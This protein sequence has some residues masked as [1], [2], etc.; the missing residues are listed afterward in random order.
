ML[1]VTLLD[2]IAVGVPVARLA[3]LA[4]LSERER[5]RVRVAPSGA[6][7][8]WDEPDA[9]VSV[10]ELLQHALANPEW[11]RE[12]ARM[13]GRQRTPRKAHASRLNGAKGGRPRRIPRAAIKTD[14]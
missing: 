9:D 10:E 14:D 13:A 4:S 1:F 7:L 8:L 6:L 12:L 2:G 5:R 3:A 11:L